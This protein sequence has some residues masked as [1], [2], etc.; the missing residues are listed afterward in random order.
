MYIN[1][2]ETYQPQNELE[3]KD[4][5]IMLKYIK[6]FKND[7]LSRENEIAHLTSS[8]FIMNEKLDKTLMVYHNIYKSWSWTGGHA[9]GEEDLLKVALK[10]AQEETGISDVKPLTK[11]MMSVDILPVWHHI[12]NGKIV[13]SHLHLNVAYLLITSES[14]TLTIKEDENSAVGWIEVSQLENYCTEPSLIPIYHK[15]INA[16]RIIKA[17]RE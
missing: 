1:E 8:G 9:D 4:K 2:I 15:L 7:V 14:E 12:K 17:Q 11:S 3:A 6:N 5:A 13:N 16:A 10:E